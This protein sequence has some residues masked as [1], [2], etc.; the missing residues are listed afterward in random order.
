MEI[1]R[2]SINFTPYVRE[3][4]S[5]KERVALKDTICAIRRDD[6]E[7][8]QSMV[9]FLLEKGNLILIK[10]PLAEQVRDK[11]DAYLGLEKGTLLRDPTAEGHA[12]LRNLESIRTRC[13]LD[14]LF[15]PAS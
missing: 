13:I 3:A 14:T 2:D 4:A 8:F 15:P 5:A 11:I 10:N 6:N 1:T 12:V 7:L 9:L